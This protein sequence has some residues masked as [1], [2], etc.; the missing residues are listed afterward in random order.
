MHIYTEMLGKDSS[1][2]FSENDILYSF[3]RDDRVGTIRL[4]LTDLN[5]G[6]ILHTVDLEIE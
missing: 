2:E 4:T 1:F 3:K 6:D 5:T